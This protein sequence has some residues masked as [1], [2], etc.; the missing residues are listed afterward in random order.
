MVLKPYAQGRALATGA[1]MLRV[2]NRC[3]VFDAAS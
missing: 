1:V 2:R 3:G